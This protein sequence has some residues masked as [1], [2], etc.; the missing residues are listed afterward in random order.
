MFLRPFRVLFRLIVCGQVGTF[1][2]GYV[3][4]LSQ[5]HVFADTP[6]MLNKVPLSRRFAV[7]FSSCDA[8]E[9]ME[10]VTFADGHV[11]V[12][13][14]Q[15]LHTHDLS[16]PVVACARLHAPSNIQDTLGPVLMRADL[17]EAACCPACGQIGKQCRCS[18][19]SYAPST[20]V[21]KSTHTWNQ[22]SGSFMYKARLGTVKLR[23][24]A[25]LSSNVE[26]CV[27]DNEVPVV[28]V[29]QKG[30][31]EYMRLLKRKAVHGLGINVVMPRA[32]T[33][34]MAQS[35]EHDFIDLHNSYITRKRIRGTEAEDAAGAILDEAVA[36]Q[37]FSL[38]L[39]LAGNMF[40]DTP[41][42]RNYADSLESVDEMLSICPGIFSTATPPHILSKGTKDKALSIERVSSPLL[43]DLRDTMQGFPPKVGRELTSDLLLG[44]T[45]STSSDSKAALQACRQGDIVDDIEQILSSSNAQAEAIETRPDMKKPLELLQP[46]EGKS[47]ECADTSATTVAAT[48]TES[49]EQ[50]VVN[51]GQLAE[52]QSRATTAKKAKTSA[53]RSKKLTD[54]EDSGADGDK[55]HACTVC[56]SR[57]KMRGDLLRH[58]KIVHEGKKMYT[59]ATCGKSFGHSGHLNRHISSVHLQQRRFKCQFCGFQFFQASHLQSHIAHIHAEKKAFSCEEC[60]FRASDHSGLKIHVEEKHAEGNENAR[61][62]LKGRGEMNA[63]EGD[64]GARFLTA[65]RNTSMTQQAEAMI[66]PLPR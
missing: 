39:S 26:M 4:G 57:F 42:D 10:F 2:L 28:N 52:M 31:T 12:M 45:F 36:D 25:V 48:V 23:M 17:F 38:D 9:F 27:I 32:D 58:V 65:H 37:P 66:A 6:L 3:W 24:T 14:R 30:D 64:V 40:A 13:F 8:L 22:F 51:R 60:G 16:L 56:A 20:A 46:G 53:K 41:D 5:P 61:G 21:R 47:I 19:E 15:F 63:Y 43:P 11:V 44:A 50:A 33:F 7:D 59:C 29:L 55:K 34:V 62:V 49:D 54:S 18:F 1:V 35:V